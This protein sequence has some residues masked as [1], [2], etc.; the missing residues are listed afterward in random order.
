[1]KLA[2]RLSSILVRDVLVIR[3]IYLCLLI[4]PLVISLDNGMGLKIVLLFIT[5]KCDCIKLRNTVRTY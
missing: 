2:I 5:N 3:C 1:M 4:Y